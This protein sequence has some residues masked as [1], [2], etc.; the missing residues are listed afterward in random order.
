MTEQEFIEHCYACDPEARPVRSVQPCGI[1][2]AD[3]VGDRS[4]DKAAAKK[5]LFKGGKT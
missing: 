1:K 3:P 2:R 5:E 4:K